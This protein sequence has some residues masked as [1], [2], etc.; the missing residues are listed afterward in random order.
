MTD[1]DPKDLADRMRHSAHGEIDDVTTDLP[2]YDRSIK[3]WAIRA[4]IA[5]VAAYSIVRY[6][7]GPAWIVPAGWT[8]VVLSLIISVGMVFMARRMITKA[9][10]RIDIAADEAERIMREDEE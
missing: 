7:N 6:A 5:L 10:K 4:G 2:T 3:I 9:H 1:D 8:Y